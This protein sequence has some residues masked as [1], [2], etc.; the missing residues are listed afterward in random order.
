MSATPR[1]LADTKFE[2]SENA[3]SES[4]P[5]PVAEPGGTIFQIDLQAFGKGCPL[6]QS[7]LERPHTP[8][9]ARMNSTGNLS[10]S[11]TH[12]F[13]ERLQLSLRAQVDPTE[14]VSVRLPFAF[15]V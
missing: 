11:I 7:A 6:R 2:L 14:A 9:L 10:T 3:F 1:L 5:N 4:G 8:P 12:R 13:S 15:P